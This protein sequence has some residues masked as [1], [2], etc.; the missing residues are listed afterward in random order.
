MGDDVLRQDMALD[1]KHPVKSGV[2]TDW[3]DVVRLWRYTFEHRLDFPA[4]D[5][6]CVMVTE[7]IQ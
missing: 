4:S 5:A 1:L 6:K 3:E 2:I 7:T